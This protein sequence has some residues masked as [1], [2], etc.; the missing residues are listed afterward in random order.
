MFRRKAAG[1]DA[2]A[3]K[4]K[5]RPQTYQQCRAFEKY[6]KTEKLFHDAMRKPMSV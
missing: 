5:L 6:L 1:G 3:V 4:W 2:L